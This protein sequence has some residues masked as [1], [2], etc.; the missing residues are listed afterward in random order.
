[1]Y[2]W[3]IERVRCPDHAITISGGTPV[4][5]GYRDGREPVLEA[6]VLTLTCLA[7]GGFLPV[8]EGDLELGGEV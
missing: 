3:S 1:L 4:A 5:P 7:E 2:R 8:V 6:P